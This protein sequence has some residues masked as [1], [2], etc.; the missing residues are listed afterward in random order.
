MTDTNNIKPSIVQ[1]A[2]QIEI[3]KTLVPPRTSLLLYIFCSNFIHGA[4][5]PEHVMLIKT[6]NGSMEIKVAIFDVGV[7]KV[8][9]YG[10]D[11]HELLARCVQID[12]AIPRGAVER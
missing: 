7:S 3:V 9:S 4:L 11:R 8:S 5:R 10:R 12:S 1:T 6:P 2:L